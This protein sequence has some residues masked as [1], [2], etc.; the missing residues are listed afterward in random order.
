MS[1]R[2]VFLLPPAGG[3]AHQYLFIARH[4]GGAVDW[5]P[6][7]YRA[8]FGRDAES[9]YACFAEAVSDLSALI[10]AVGIG[11][12]IGLVGHSLG[13][14]LAFEVGRMLRRDA[15]VDLDA[16]EISSAEPPGRQRHT[17][18]RLFDLDDDRLLDHLLGLEPDSATDPV[19]RRLLAS[20]LPLIRADHRL[21]H[22]HEPDPDAVIDVPLHV[23]WGDADT[24]DATTARAWGA[25]TDAGATF[26]RVPGGHLHWKTTPSALADVIDLAFR[27]RPRSAPAE[28]GER[29]SFRC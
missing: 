11:R 16:I 5:R 8:H 12:R 10:T 15:T 9:P 3:G 18:T 22:S 29:S 1:D 23:C 4:L 27:V 2:I 6:L 25:H 28:Q 13:G 7:D 19:T 24:L 21:H 26:H 17:S 20:N 14:S